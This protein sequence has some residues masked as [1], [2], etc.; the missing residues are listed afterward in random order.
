MQALIYISSFGELDATGYIP[1]CWAIVHQ[2]CT[3]N[4]CK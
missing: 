1:V 2:V 3:T 4:A